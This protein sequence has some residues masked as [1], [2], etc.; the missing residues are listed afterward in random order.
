MHPGF[1]TEARHGGGLIEKDEL[2]QG[3]LYPTTLPA[4][5]EQDGMLGYRRSGNECFMELGD[6]YISKLMPS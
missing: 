2:L 4:A 5:Q 3:C 6:Q 1:G